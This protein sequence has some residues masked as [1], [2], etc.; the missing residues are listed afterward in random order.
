MIDYEFLSGGVYSGIGGPSGD[1]E[2][3]Q[4]TNFDWISIN[5]TAHSPSVMRPHAAAVERRT[6]GDVVVFD[7]AV[8]HAQWRDALCWKRALFSNICILYEAFFFKG[9]PPLKRQNSTNT[10]RVFKFDG[11]IVGK[12]MKSY[13]ENINY[14]LSQ[15]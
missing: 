10:Q 1:T 9:F 4:T 3:T 6:G 2:G 7:R 14:K 5:S 8:F 11:K 12:T 13:M 15:Q